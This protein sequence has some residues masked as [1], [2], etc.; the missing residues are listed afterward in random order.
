[1]ATN[2]AIDQ[3]LLQKALEVSGLKTKRETV[4]LALQEFVNRHKQLEL[5]DLF[6]K[7][8]PDADYDYKKGRTR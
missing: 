2:L 1:M 4:N 7:M 3:A 5:L 8:D 6:G